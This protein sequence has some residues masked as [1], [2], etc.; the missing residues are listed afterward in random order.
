VYVVPKLRKR[1]QSLLEAA[2]ISLDDPLAFSDEDAAVADF[3]QIARMVTLSDVARRSREAST[4]I[5]KNLTA[6][7]ESVEAHAKALKQFRIKP[8]QVSVNVGDCRDLAAC[9]IECSIQIW[10]VV[11]FLA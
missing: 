3:L 9:G 10:L 4:Y 2:T 8:G 7:L 11:L 5:R 1:V 6:M